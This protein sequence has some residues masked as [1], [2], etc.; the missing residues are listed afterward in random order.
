[1]DAAGDTHNLTIGGRTRTGISNEVNVHMGNEVQRRFDEQLTSLRD[2]RQRSMTS[3]TLGILSEMQGR[4][5]IN[6]LDKVA[7][8][9]YLLCTDSIPIYDTEQPEP[10]VWEV[11]VDAMSSVCRAEL[12]FYYPEPGTG[13]KLWRP[14]WQQVMKQKII[15]PSSSWPEEVS[16]TDDTDTDWYEGYRIESACV[17]GLGEVPNEDMPRV[18]ELF[19]ED[20]TC[21]PHTVRV[22]AHH[23]YPI[24]DGLY[25]LIGCNLEFSSDIW[26]VGRLR[27]DGM[28]EKLSV[29]SSVEDGQVKLG[30]LDLEK[31][32][33]TFLC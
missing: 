22:V 15:A 17:W 8:L 20:S 21:K 6:P 10:G 23:M 4:V 14:S 32:L 18:G 25:T 30:N 29:F 28:F 12:F 16:R 1:M 5:S 24:P 13:T 26:V 9:V 2:I 3:T 31:R 19:F 7:G 33:R 27:D 11:L